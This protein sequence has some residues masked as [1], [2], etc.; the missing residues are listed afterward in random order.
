MIQ[1]RTSYFYYQIETFR[2][3]HQCTIVSVIA[4][5]SEFQVLPLHKAIRH[6]SS[7]SFLKLLSPISP[8]AK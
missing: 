7:E 8:Y 5:H 2:E 4:C 1:N 3:L 6:I